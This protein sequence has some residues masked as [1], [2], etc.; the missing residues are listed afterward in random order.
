[1]NLGTSTIVSHIP[2]R[3]GGVGFSMF[4]TIF[5]NYQKNDPA[6]KAGRVNQ[7]KNL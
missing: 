7:T 1:M 6:K 4:T 3:E 5:I 2:S